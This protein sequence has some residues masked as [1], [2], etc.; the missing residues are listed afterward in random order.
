MVGGL[1]ATIAKI[2][3]G[4]FRV[5]GENFAGYVPAELCHHTSKK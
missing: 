2:G 3:D 5:T 1:K 4:W